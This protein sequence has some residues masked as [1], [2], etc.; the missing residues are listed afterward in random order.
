MLKK[1]LRVWHLPRHRSSLELKLSAGRH[2]GEVGLGAGAGTSKDAGEGVG[3]HTEAHTEADA[4]NGSSIAT[5][6]LG[7][8]ACAREDG[9]RRDGGVAS[10]ERQTGAGAGA[11]S[12]EAGK[13]LPDPTSNPRRSRVHS[14]LV[15]Y[16]WI[17][18]GGL[19]QTAQEITAPASQLRDG[20]FKGMA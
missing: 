6:G 4:G 3:V 12:D 1:H 19:R 11:G 17:A 14:G 7:A 13:R 8:D 18:N 10:M 5:A 15:G 16:Q 9:D 2:V 20:C